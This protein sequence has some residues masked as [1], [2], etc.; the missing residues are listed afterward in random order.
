MSADLGIRRE[1]KSRW[2]RRAPL[3]PGH[4]EELVRAQGRSVVVQPSSIR[5]F[6]DDDYARAGATLNEDLSA[7][8]AILA[9]KE[10]PPALLLPGKAYTAFF[11]VIKGQA[12]NLPQLRRALELRCT[13]L[14]YERVVDRFG[15]RLIFFGRHAGYAGMVDALWGLG[16]RLLAE[17]IETPF[18]AVEPAHRY[19]SVEHASQVLAERVGRQIREQGIDPALHPLVVGFTGGGNVSQGAQEILDHLPVVEVHP[20]QLPSLAAD[21]GLSRRAVYKTV[22]RREHRQHF[23]RHLPYLTVLV[24]GIFWQPGD[25][26]LVTKDDV[27][28]LWE[29]SARPSLRLLADLSCDLDGAIEVTTRIASIDDPLYVYEPQTGRTPSGVE[30]HGP[31]VFAVDNLPAELPRDASEHFG[32]SLFPFL[33]GLA[34]ANFSVSYEHLALPA[35]LLGAVVAHGG[36]LTPGYRYLEGHLARMAPEAVAAAVAGP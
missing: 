28:E 23:A 17:G 33:S 21:P 13:L 25:P 9:I 16:R 30:G 31:V 27:T 19:P 20:D 10:I 35:A 24:N 29:A 14:D 1:D 4:V 6:P 2:E 18:A 34:G 5:V 15:R 22:F 3:T 26:R 8:R 11:H 7:C 36:E 32:D 12:K